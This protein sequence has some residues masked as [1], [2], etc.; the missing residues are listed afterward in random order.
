MKKQ[1]VA[2]AVVKI[3]FFPPP[4]PLPSSCTMFSLLVLSLVIMHASLIVQ[5]ACTRGHVPR[6]TEKAREKTRS[7]LKIW[8]RRKSSRENKVK[9]SSAVIKWLGGR[10]GRGGRKRKE[11]RDGLKKQGGKTACL[12]G[13][14]NPRGTVRN[15][16]CSSTSRYAIPSSL[17]PRRISRSSRDAFVDKEKRRASFRPAIDRVSRDVPRC[18][19]ERERERERE[20]KD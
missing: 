13:H 10:G 19:R 7:C 16:S 11:R 5:V 4:P 12:L 14:E 6:E 3:N 9:G 8:S 15:S 17:C 1:D 2:V 20:M 18:W